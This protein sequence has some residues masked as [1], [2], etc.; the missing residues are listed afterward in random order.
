MRTII[1]SAILWLFI[2]CNT[3]KLSTYRKCNKYSN[4]CNTVAVNELI[5][6]K[7]KLILSLNSKSVF[8]IQK[9]SNNPQL[10]YLDLS[11]NP[12]RDISSLTNVTN[13]S[14]LNLN[15]TCVTNLT[16]LR[17]LT[18]LTNL[19]ILRTY[20]DDLRCVPKSIKVIYVDKDFPKS[21]LR[22]FKKRVHECIVRYD[23]GFVPKDNLRKGVWDNPISAE[24]LKHIA[25]VK[26]AY[27]TQIKFDKYSFIV[28]V[29]NSILILQGR[30]VKS[31]K[32]VAVLKNL[33]YLDISNTYIRDIS[34]LSN[35]YNLRYLDIS[36]TQIQE[37]KHIKNLRNLKTL[38][39]LR[40]KIKSLKNVPNCV[41]ILHI[42]MDFNKKEIRKF[43][44]RNPK[45]RILFS[46]P[47]IEKNERLKEK[48]PWKDRVYE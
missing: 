19:H 3:H 8:S 9:I 10:W 44:D 32:G 27:L 6:L 23:D 4:C 1:F 46:R 20:I 31:I 45:C 7:N 15:M 39:M 26:N 21:S 14:F 18:K 34:M 36:C 33:T 25:T 30:G 13:I 11:N 38:L 43:K 22:R 5:S 35:S 47:L 16:V 29:R 12:L 24:K 2:S 48:G 41:E 40:T 37:I 28:D 17:N 42:D